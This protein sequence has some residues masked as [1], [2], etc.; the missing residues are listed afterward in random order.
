M[1]NKKLGM[2]GLI[3]MTAM[4]TLSA[5]PH[6]VN[7]AENK[8]IVYV[9]KKDV[10][11]GKV[12]IKDKDVKAIV[13]KKSVKS[14][15]VKLSKVKVSGTITFEKGDYILQTKKSSIKGIKITQKDTNV[16]LD[17]ASDLNEKNFA[18]KV[19]KGAAGSIDL[20]AYNKKVTADLGE[21]T[22][23]SITVGEKANAELR[24]KKAHES[25]ELDING[26]S[27]NAMLSKITLEG[28]VSLV[29]NVDV[30]TL[31]TT[32]KAAKATVTVSKTIDNIKN[33]GN[34]EIKQLYADNNKE[35]MPESKS[36]DD[37]V[38]EDKTKED[39]TKPD[40]GGASGGG[41]YA[42]GG[43]ASPAPGAPSVKPAENIK[44]ET[45]SFDITEDDKEFE[46][47]VKYEPANT[48][49]EIEWTIENGENTT[50]KK[51]SENK[52]IIRLKALDNGEYKIKAK[53][54]GKDKVI[55]G[56]GN[57]SGQKVGLTS[58]SE[59]VAG[60]KKITGLQTGKRY[61]LKVDGKYIGIGADGTVSNTK[62]S[63]F[64]SAYN[65]S[66]DLTVT[67]TKQGLENSKT[68]EIYKT[69]D[70]ERAIEAKYNEYKAKTV[71]DIGFGNYEKI[72]SEIAKLRT[73]LAG[74][75]SADQTADKKWEKMRDNIEAHLV[76]LKTE[77]ENK[78]NIFDDVETE[79]K[80]QYNKIKNYA[81]TKL[82]YS[83]ASNAIQEIE[84]Q[85]KKVGEEFLIGEN[86]ILK[87]PEGVIYNAVKADVGV[88]KLL[89]N[90]SYTLSNDGQYVFTFTSPKTNIKWEI[91]KLENTNDYQST[92]V[93]GDI[94]AN[95][96]ETFINL[97]DKFDTLG[98]GEYCVE[99]TAEFTTLENFM[100]K[101]N[102]VTK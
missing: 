26:T 78:K 34:T 33:A 64:N 47:K 81:D 25:S 28:P 95:P 10:K 52:N 45:E 99:I 56:S 51:I 102:L 43:S 68:Y 46:I 86:K 49:G 87:Q 93:R 72:L 44:F 98:S 35:E 9:T 16:K 8:D 89:M 40:T 36:S 38:K 54:K 24:I 83:D 2:C 90:G 1:K 37:K 4:C 62:Y 92:G 30:S 79:I 75:A 101:S 84:E 59:G 57:I 13:V 5:V 39:K 7:A 77:A 96:S 48:V 21:N 70:E 19:S 85:I 18:L 31:E 50:V 73:D 66:A 23:F 29:V 97:K 58:G 80:K 6:K 65:N 17:K 74:K 88:Y 15:T 61:V 14:A 20:S 41:G 67:E 22:H 42:G 27:E 69:D 76:Q 63:D 55:T 60:D 53:L 71:S 11:N 94:Q 12:I 3:L 91:K 32:E 82:S 100:H